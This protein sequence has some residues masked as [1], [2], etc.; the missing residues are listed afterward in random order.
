MGVVLH[1]V[2]SESQWTVLMGYLIISATVRRYQTHHSR[3][4]SGRQRTDPT[5]VAL[6]TNTAFE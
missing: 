5:A 2:W 3:R 6:L 1:Q 4:P